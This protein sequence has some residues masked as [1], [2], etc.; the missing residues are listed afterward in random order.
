MNYQIDEI[1]KEVNQ[2]R[3]NYQDML[4]DSQTDTHHKNLVT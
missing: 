1:M 4:F 3:V 2:T